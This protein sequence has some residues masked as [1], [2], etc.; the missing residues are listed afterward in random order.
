MNRLH[1]QD[2]QGNEFT[3]IPQQR[4]HHLAPTAGGGAEIDY[5]HSGL[6]QLVLFLQLQQFEGR[7]ANAKPFCWA[8]F[9]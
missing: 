6:Y 8:I 5:Y 9:T 3:G 7:S 1:F 4:L 2:I